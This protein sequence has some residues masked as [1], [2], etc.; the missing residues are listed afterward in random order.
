MNEKFKKDE[1]WGHL[2]KNKAQL[3]DTDG[4]LG[5]DEDEAALDYDEAEAIKSDIKVGDLFRFLLRTTSF[6]S[7]MLLT[8]IILFLFFKISF[9]PY[10]LFM[11]RTTFSIRCLVVQ[12]TGG[13]GMGGPGSLSS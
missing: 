13:H 7:L 2:G 1:V 11:L 9:S 5:E 4:E 6:L 8:T 3:R 12:W 10:S